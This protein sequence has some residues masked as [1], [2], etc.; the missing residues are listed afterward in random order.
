MRI[1]LAMLAA[2]AIAPLWAQAPTTLPAGLDYLKG[3]DNDRDRFDAPRFRILVWFDRSAFPWG[4]SEKQINGFR[5]RRNFNVASRLLDH[6]KTNYVKISVDGQ[7]PDDTPPGAGLEFDRLHGTNPKRTPSDEQTNAVFVFPAGPEFD[8]G[9]Y[10][11]D[12]GPASAFTADFR[13]E[14]PYVVPATASNLIVE[15]GVLSTTQT[16]QYPIDQEWARDFNN[17]PTRDRGGMRRIGQH[18]PPS[19]WP[20]TRDS[21]TLPCFM[22]EAGGTG[23]VPGER[24]RFDLFSGVDGRAACWW[25]GPVLQTPF[26]IPG[27]SCTVYVFPD[28]FL[29]AMTNND[30]SEPDVGRLNIAF[31][32]PN[33]SSLVGQCVGLQ[34]A[35]HDGNGDWPAGLGVSAG[36]ELTIGTGNPNGDRFRTVYAAVG[37]NDPLPTEGTL[38]WSAPIFEIY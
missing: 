6:T 10:Q 34:F 25:L 19:A 3:T 22:A 17:N 21:T 35:V 38:A 12:T 9:I 27:T 29:F 8:P 11:N 16:D 7:K 20:C 1:A 31:N 15:I 2:V 37:E 4:A 14:A 30:S 5:L 28:C 26:P 23:L 18:C 33:T 24:A 32:V 36:F 13:L